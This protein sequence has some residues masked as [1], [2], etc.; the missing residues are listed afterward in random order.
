MILLLSSKNL[1]SALK[2][3]DVGNVGKVR[4]VH[5]AVAPGKPLVAAYDSLRT[6]FQPA[7]ARPLP[8]GRPRTAT[9]RPAP[10]TGRNET[11]TGSE[12]RGA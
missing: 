8:Q 10:H 2:E 7:L 9:D 4:R 12:F 6:T 11:R 1:I 3:H 5:G